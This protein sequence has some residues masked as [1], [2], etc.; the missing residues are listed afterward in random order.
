MLDLLEG[1]SAHFHEHHEAIL[2]WTWKLFC[3]KWARLIRATATQ[4]LEREESERKQRLGEF[5]ANHAGDWE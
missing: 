2:R 5:A 3:A 4:R 1:M